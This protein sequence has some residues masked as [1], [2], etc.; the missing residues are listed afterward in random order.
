MRRLA[1]LP[2]AMTVHATFP[3]LVSPVAA[4]LRFGDVRDTCLAFS[5]CDCDVISVRQLVVTF[6]DVIDTRSINQSARRVG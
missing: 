5:C 6:H 4:Y 3:V 1:C 2:V